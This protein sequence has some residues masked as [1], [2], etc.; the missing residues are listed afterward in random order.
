MIIQNKAETI[1]YKINFNFIVIENKATFEFSKDEIE[2]SCGDT[3]N[4]YV[5]IAPDLESLQKVRHEVLFRG[6]ND[7]TSP[8]LKFADVGSNIQAGALH[9]IIILYDNKFLLKLTDFTKST[10]KITKKQHQQ[11]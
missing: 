2:K 6:I 1:F 7:N 4:Y 9:S 11:R 8:D 10:P 3:L 5:L